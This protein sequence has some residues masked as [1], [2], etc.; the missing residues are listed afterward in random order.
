MKTLL[1]LVV[2]LFCVTTFAQEQ[3]VDFKKIDNDLTK[4]TYY[5]ADNAN[6]VEREGFFNKSGKL[7]GTWINYDVNGSKTIIANYKNGK[8]EG[9]WSFIKK[10]KVNLVTYKNN[11]VVNV[12][13]KDIIIN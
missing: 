11:K 9:T 4:A 7:H 5:F 8:K 1:K 12:E 13:T 10:D 2:L 6:I 3:K